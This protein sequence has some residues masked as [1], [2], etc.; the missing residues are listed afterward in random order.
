MTY[1]LTVIL[2]IYNME[3]HLERCL[4]SVLEQTDLETLKI[5]LVCVNDGS[6]DS[7]QSILQKYAQEYSWI[8]VFEKENGGVSSAR[9]F[10]LDHVVDSRYVTFL[11]PDD[12]WEPNYLEAILPGIESDAD[13]IFFNIN[14]VDANGELVK[15]LAVCPNYSELNEEEAKRRFILS[16]PASWTRIHKAE[17]FDGHRFPLGRIYEDLALMPYVTSLSTSI[18]YVK[19]YVYNYVIDVN[20]SIMNSS[21]SAIFDIYPAL[22]YLWNLFGKQ[23]E[24]YR[25]ELQYLMLEHL[26]VG[27]SY[28]LIGYQDAAPRDYDLITDYLHKKFGKNWR[29]NKYI[30]A[31]V[32]KVNINSALGSVVPQFLAVLQSGAVRFTPYGTKIL[33]KVQSFKK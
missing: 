27:Q 24:N 21:K 30:D 1:D 19:D 25:D 18:Y 3:E 4:E 32:Q 17:L 22:D 33:R 8:E 16:K 28:R 10:G 7:T 20:N 12:T 29:K 26:G 31:G 23:T 5:R 2:A 11:D 6:T 9:N 15:K 14:L 13:S